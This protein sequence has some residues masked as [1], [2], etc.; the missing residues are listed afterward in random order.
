VA[1]LGR[2][3]RRRDDACAALG[4]GRDRRALGRP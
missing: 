1:H 2:R 3:R 4:P